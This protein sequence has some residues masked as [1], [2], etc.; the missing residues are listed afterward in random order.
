MKNLIIFKNKALISLNQ[1]DPRIIE[2]LRGYW[3]IY[4]T[5]PAVFMAFLLAPVITVIATITVVILV[6]SDVLLEFQVIQIIRL[7]V[8]EQ[9]RDVIGMLRLAG[10]R[11]VS[12]PSFSEGFEIKSDR[13]RWIKT[14]SG[15]IPKGT[16][17]TLQRDLM[18]VHKE[19]LRYLSI[20]IWM[21]QC[22]HLRPAFK[23]FLARLEHMIAANG[24]TYTFK[25][26]KEVLRLLVRALAGNAELLRPFEP[27]VIRMKL[28]KYGLPKMLPLEM[29]S[30][31]R[32]YIDSIGKSF[33]VKP[34][35]EPETGRWV[36]LESPVLFTQKGIVAVLTMVAIF[37]VLSTKVD[38]SLK[39]I[40][41]N[42][43]GLEKSLPI[44]MIKA[45]LLA[46]IP[47][48]RK[49][50]KELKRME[51]VGGGIRLT[52]GKFIPHMSTKAGPNGKL[53]TWGSALDAIAF[54]HE[55]RKAVLLL[56]W[57]MD[58]K[59]YAY[60]LWFVLLNITFGLTYI[61]W[62]Y[63]MIGIKFI[64]GVVSKYG[65]SRLYYSK[66]F[67]ALNRFSQ[68]FRIG[69]GNYRG[70]VGKLYLGGLGVVYD[71]A[72]KARVVAKTNWWYQSAFKGLHD[73]IFSILKQIPSDATFDQDL[74][75]KTFLANAKL[76]DNLSG[77]DLTAATDRLPI[78]LQA[79]ILDA[80]GVDGR[81]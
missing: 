42:F 5:Y 23:L 43:S 10:D 9:L 44:P 18:P 52:I 78:D 24:S 37:R 6:L 40:V 22:P 28:D 75:F 76:S 33:T 32:G 68:Y 17:P 29:R 11:L 4:F 77:Y 35:F 69:V 65:G 2:N 48:P 3:L 1:L 45:A 64:L 38:A 7:I 63:L 50:N 25:Y 12:I 46:L 72:G 57:M 59:A 74:A 53:S 71:Q 41:D 66:F 61:V 67:A 36:T 56:L 54:M 21:T 49:W 81:T 31:I 60:I 62:Y 20:T 79:D 51:S 8:L 30:E 58:Q 27:G 19:L 39:S 55:P 14:N 15:K 16:R 47:G 70:E 26:L 34:I 73:S 80:A 13:K